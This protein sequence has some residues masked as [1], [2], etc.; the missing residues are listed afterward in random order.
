MWWSKDRIAQLAERSGSVVEADQYHI[1]LVHVENDVF[2]L[3]LRS[4]ALFWYAVNA[5]VSAG[6]CYNQLARLKEHPKRKQW[7]RRWAMEWDMKRDIERGT[8]S[9]YQ[10]GDA[11][12]WRSQ[13]ADGISCGCLGCATSFSGSGSD[14]CRA[15]T[16][17][18]ERPEC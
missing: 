16:T 1:A 11:K 15:V 5:A 4:E 14:V 12:V 17:S 8:E 3:C 13:Y 9:G 7:Y 18:F 6:V 10:R 2:M